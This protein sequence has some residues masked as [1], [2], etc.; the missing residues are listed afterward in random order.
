M[1][2]IMAQKVPTTGAPIGGLRRADFKGGDDFELHGYWMH[3]TRR[4]NV[5]V[6][7]FQH[8]FYP[9]LAHTDL[10][11]QQNISYRTV[12]V[13]SITD[14]HNAGIQA[15][16]AIFIAEV[17]THP[18]YIKHPNYFRSDFPANV[19][20]LS[21]QQD[22]TF[23]IAANDLPF[24]R[25]KRKKA[26][27]YWRAAFSP[28]YIKGSQYTSGRMQFFFVAPPHISAPLRKSLNLEDIN[29][30]WEQAIAAVREK[31]GVYGGISRN[32]MQAAV[33][34]QVQHEMQEVVFPVL[35]SQLNVSPHSAEGRKLNK[36]LQDP[37]TVQ[38]FM[39]ATQHKPSH[40][41]A[42]KQ[43]VA[44]TFWPQLK[45]VVGDE[46]MTALESGTRFMIRLAISVAFDG[47]LTKLKNLPDP[48]PGTSA[49]RPS[50]WR[51]QV[52]NTAGKIDY[53]FMQGFG[54]SHQVGL[55]SLSYSARKRNSPQDIAYYQAYIGRIILDQYRTMAGD[56]SLGPVG[57]DFF[58]ITI[59]PQGTVDVSFDEVAIE[60]HRHHSR[61][62]F[63]ELGRFAEDGWLQWA[64]I[65]IPVLEKQ[66]TEIYREIQQTGF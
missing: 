45:H 23:V 65:Y 63:T 37:K 35:S 39:Q 8:E 51:S 17:W 10:D 47:V 57:L 1:A 4:A 60:R 58:K 64:K 30:N 26:L 36:L 27:N 56:H 43:W 62:N 12:I 14:L 48:T 50:P 33:Q 40:F 5:E 54:D 31:H 20:T 44:H 6:P 24:A 9:T 22:I 41:Y 34:K 55:G 38:S 25:I 18:R 19:K 49:R 29:E 52:R 61:E 42:V 11:V 21:R 28:L 3:P 7:I 15:D 53:N 13:P 2:R 46:A 16:K 59:L 32:R 66:A